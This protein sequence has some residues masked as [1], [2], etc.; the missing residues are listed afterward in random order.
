MRVVSALDQRL[1]ELYQNYCT[2]TS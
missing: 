2:T 1:S